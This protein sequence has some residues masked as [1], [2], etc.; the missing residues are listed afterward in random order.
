MT[1]ASF[2]KDRAIFIVCGFVCAIG[3]SGMFA[4]LGQGWAISIFAVV[5][6]LGCWTF[7]LGI[8]Y[9]RRRRFYRELSFL[10]DGLDD[11]YYAAALLECPSHLEGFL[12][13]RALETVGKSASDKVAFYRKEVQAYK[14]Y[15]ELWIHEIKTPIAAARL[16]VTGMRGSEAAKIASGIDRIES[17]VE[18]ALYY[19]R[20]ASLQKDYFIREVSL[21]EVVRGVIKKYARYLIE[22]NTMPSIE[23]SEDVRVFADSKWLGFI[24]GQ[25]VV[26]SA[27]YNARTLRFSSLEADGATGM[28]TLLKIADD[29]CGIP[30]TD[31][32]RVFERGF[33]GENGRVRGSS[34]GMGLYLVASLCK[35]MGLSVSL[36]SCVGEGT[37]VSITFPHDR[38][39]LDR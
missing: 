37:C 20:S 7:A 34:T 26:N 24:I 9:A 28:T 22:E 35:K 17:F 33:T 11:A 36:S 29:G 21:A 3:I 12:T 10:L 15:I 4:A 8:D 32:P 2:L 1:F 30:P 27:Q 23:I 13:Y 19:A 39:R 6:V 14:D 31:T 25:V 16:V 38:R 18:Q 5:F